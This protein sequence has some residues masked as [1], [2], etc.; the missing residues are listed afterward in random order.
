MTRSAFYY[1][2]QS[3]ECDESS[4][5]LKPRVDGLSCTQECDAGS[6]SD[7][8]ITN[9][10]VEQTCSLC[11]ANTYSVPGLFV[12]GQMGDWLVYHSQYQ[13][14]QAIQPFEFHCLYL[15]QLK[16]WIQ[17][18]DCEPWRPLKNGI[19]AGQSDQHDT[20]VAFEI[21]YM[22]D[23]VKPGYV[24]FKY[25]KDSFQIDNVRNGFFEFFVNDQEVF[26]DRLNENHKWKVQSQQIDSPGKKKLR[27]V[28]KKHNGQNSGTS[29]LVELEYVKIIG[30][31][32]AATE[33]IPCV[34]GYSTKGSDRCDS[35]EA[36]YYFDTKADI[37]L[38]KPCAQDQYSFPGS[39][40]QDSCI[41]RHPCTDKDHIM[42][43]SECIDGSRQ[44]S[45]QYIQP[46]QCDFRNFM[47][48]VQKTESCTQC[49][50]QNQYLNKS[51][52]ECQTCPNN[53]YLSYE[54][55]IPK[56]IKCQS[57]QEQ[58]KEEK[59]EMFDKVP[60][61]F[62]KVCTVIN[63]E[64]ANP[65]ICN[66]GY[67]VPRGV[68]VILRKYIQIT[69][70]RIGEVQIK[71][72]ALKLNQDEKVQIL[73]N[74][75]VKRNYF[76]QTLTLDE[77]LQDENDKEMQYNIKLE[78]NSY[79]L[80]IAFQTD[81]DLDKPSEG[82]VQDARDV[83]KVKQQQDPDKNVQNAEQTTDVINAHKIAQI[84]MQGVH[85]NNVQY[86]HFLH[87]IRLCKQILLLK[88]IISC[89]VYDRIQLKNHIQVHPHQL[90]S[91][92]VCS[93]YIVDNYC[94]NQ[95]MGPILHHEQNLLTQ[96]QTSEMFFFADH[97]KFELRTY[98]YHELKESN[99]IGYIFG[100]FPFQESSTEVIQNEILQNNDKL[101][102]KCLSA[103]SFMRIKQNLGSKISQVFNITKNGYTVR[104]DQGDKC[105]HDAKQNYSSEIRYICNVNSDDMGWPVYSSKQGDCHYIFE[106]QSKYACTQCLINQVMTVRSPCENGVRN[107][108]HYPLENCIIQSQAELVTA[109][110]YI[111]DSAA[112]NSLYVDDQGY[113]ETC[114]LHEEIL[115]NPILIW[116]LIG[117]LITLLLLIV[118][119]CIVCHKHKDLKS[120][121]DVLGDGGEGDAQY[122]DQKSLKYD[123][124]T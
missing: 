69:N 105:K 71:Y 70:E 77:T 74:G 59:Y 63:S 84:L 88:F 83:Q 101:S 42:S 10:R 120:K 3:Y 43:F 6:F 97:K 21:I 44:V 103:I 17:D 121:Y 123:S 100:L 91:Q 24:E 13:K 122:G 87:L 89:I 26:V 29:L 99:Q 49:T 41:K 1:Y 116:S 112:D 30:T 78:E 22:A 81:T 96:Q 79:V 118:I 117:V 82:E 80:D 34:K 45:Y 33:C 51:S 12:D 86:T 76:H 60:D 113:S 56:C 102:E 14:M 38:C 66:F 111:E 119:I 67:G 28:Y 39:V 9:N 11:P 57:G 114:Y 2:P 4:E 48:P 124:Q 37:D 85:A 19:V 16:R 98:E 104:Y 36:N 109:K 107:V 7:F 94:E 35:C 95:I 31:K 65:K 18:K 90:D 23:F 46:I 73:L 68:R 15:D 50:Q 55:E 62:H 25:K 61:T 5:V 58:V 53:T 32:Q 92:S 54:Q 8:N 52:N 27:W 75:H 115:I 110:L 93:Y 64:V 72:K 106:W 47:L 20:E 108:A 40:G